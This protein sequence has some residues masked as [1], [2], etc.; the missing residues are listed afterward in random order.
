MEKFLGAGSE[1]RLHISSSKYASCAWIFLLTCQ[2][3]SCYDSSEIIRHA[4]LYRWVRLVNIST[5]SSRNAARTVAGIMWSRT[6]TQHVGKSEDKKNR[7][8]WIWY[9]SWRY[10]HPFHE[11][12]FKN[13]NKNHVKWL[14]SCALSLVKHD[15]FSQKIWILPRKV[16]SYSS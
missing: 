3:I 15:Q 12:Q 16:T 4:S 2:V 14:K 5:D 6:A 13:K 1:L 7:K 9:A 10:L 8:L 11:E